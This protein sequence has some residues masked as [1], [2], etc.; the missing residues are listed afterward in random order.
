MAHALAGAEKAGE[1][2]REREKREKKREKERGPTACG[3][4]E[5]ERAH[6]RPDG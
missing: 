5:H 1:K 6:G 3:G 4:K 2:E